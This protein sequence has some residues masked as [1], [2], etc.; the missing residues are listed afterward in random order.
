M[1]EIE[2]TSSIE[3][4]SRMSG[5]IWGQAKCGKTTLLTS[6]PGKKL[7]VMVD[8]DGDQSLPDREDIHIVRLYEE[9][10]DVIL[11]WLTDKFPTFIRK[12]EQSFD[13]VIVDSLSTFGTAALNEAIR[14]KVGQSRDFTP[15][16]EAPGLG[17]YGARTQYIGTMVS[18]VL[19]ATSSV[20]IHCFFTAHEDE[21]DRDK[22]GVVLGITPTLSG[23]ATNIVG[24]NVSEL[25]FMSKADKKWRLAISP[26]RSRSPMGSRIF[27]VTG[28]PEF[29]L[30]FNPEKGLDQPHSIATW[31]QQWEA[32]G[33][34]KLPLPK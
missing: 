32:G 22:N 14:A 31:F 34:K 1:A 7:F 28:E 30:K 2:I 16:I 21:P 33:R 13:S 9:P 10:D 25:W 6:L 29:D 23:K 26:C 17:A 19:R 4:K 5:V 8:P 15:S 11:R 20:G 27:D 3:R 24:L 18:K 12:N